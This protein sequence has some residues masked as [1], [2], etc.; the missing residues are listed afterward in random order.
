MNGL[1]TR[2]PD[3]IERLASAES[4]AAARAIV[5]EFRAAIERQASLY[6]KVE[7]IHRNIR[8]RAIRAVAARLGV[9]PDTIRAICDVQSSGIIRRIGVTRFDLMDKILNGEIQ[10]NTDEEV[11]AAFKNLVDETVAGLTAALKQVDDLNPPLPTHVADT[12]K[13]KLCDLQ[14]F[15]TIDV[16]RIADEVSR[17]IDTAHLDELLRGNAGK[18]A[19]Q[20]ELVQI[21]ATLN[22]IMREMLAGREEIGPDDKDG[23][24]SI[25]RTLI[26]AGRPGLADRL[27]AFFL[28]PDVKAEIAEHNEKRT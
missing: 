19:I 24:L 20:N 15:D 28:R 25:A 23:I 4:Q 10:A 17:R 5:A 27:D 12:I 9:A 7:P 14:K 2:H 11:E 8:E 26:V 16:A 1:A 13:A 3:L 21:S 18:A 22:G 6:C